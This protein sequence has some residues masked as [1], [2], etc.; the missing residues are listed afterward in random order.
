MNTWTPEQSSP[1]HLIIRVNDPH[2]WF[3]SEFQQTLA[4]HIHILEA[5]PRKDLNDVKLVVEIVNH[6]VGI[7]ASV[8]QIFTFLSA[9]RDRAAQSMPQ[10]DIQITTSDG[11]SINLVHDDQELLKSL[12]GIHG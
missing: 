5:V 10:P 6:G 8:A 11:K 3:I 9:A 1:H 2:N 4:D 12:L 7:A